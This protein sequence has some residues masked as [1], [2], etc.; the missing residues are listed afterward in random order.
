[1]RREQI[2]K[3]VLNHLVTEDF[4]AQ[5]KPMNTSGKAFCWV[6]MNYAEEEAAA[7]QLAV[8]FKNEELA[9]QFKN[10]IEECIEK[11]KQFKANK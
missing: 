2:F 10:Q 9:Q 3:L 4:G 11:I 7:E 5:F 8:R 6:S 1:M